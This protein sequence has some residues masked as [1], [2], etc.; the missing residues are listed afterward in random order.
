M[1]LYKISQNKNVDYDTYDSAVVCAE[2]VDDAKQWNPTGKK[3]VTTTFESYS[4]WTTIEHVKVEEI[5]EAKEGMKE[6]I[7]VA[8]FNAG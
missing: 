6:G 5:G 8:S 1:K 7:I 3:N 4:S 2:S